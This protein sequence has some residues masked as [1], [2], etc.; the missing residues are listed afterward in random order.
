ME[1]SIR[2]KTIALAGIFQ[3]AQLVNKL[4]YTGE[5]EKKYAEASIESLFA[6]EANSIDDVF[7]GLENLHSG[8]KTL[9]EHLANPA[10]DPK[11]MEITRYTIA[12]T[13]LQRQLDR[14]TGMGEQL[15]SSIE[16]TGRQR[17][18]FGGTMNPAVISRLAEIY[19]E[20][21]S[22]LSPKIIVKGDQTYLSNPDIAAQIRASLLAG[23]RA[24]VL[25]KQSGGGRFDLFFSRRKMIAEAKRLLQDNVV[26]LR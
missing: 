25:W 7:G 2:N 9:V 11:S 10:Q 12:L 24:A 23:I 14:Q 15:I 6:N 21:I 3:A 8:L 1:H 20:T 5:A 26:P 22:Q 17:E 19:K 13:H 16:D 18:Y 4:A